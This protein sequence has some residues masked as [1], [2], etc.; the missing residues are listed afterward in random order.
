MMYRSCC[1]YCEMTIALASPIDCNVNT[2]NM[3]EGE[4]RLCNDRIVVF[5]YSSRFPTVSVCRYTPPPRCS[6]AH[7]AMLIT[8][9]IQVSSIDCATRYVCTLRRTAAHSPHRHIAFAIA[10]AIDINTTNL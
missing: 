6:A 9:D 5:C 7:G 8:S 4:T 2:R 10:I 1:L 3:V